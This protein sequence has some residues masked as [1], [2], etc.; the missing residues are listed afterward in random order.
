MTPEMTPEMR[1]SEM[2]TP[3]EVAPA[4]RIPVKRLYLLVAE[5]AVPHVRLGRSV[6]FPRLAFEEWMSRQSQASL[7]SLAAV[8]EAPLAVQEAPHADAA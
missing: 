3:A 8:Q 4:L 5:G 7:A 1:L 6:R 2:L